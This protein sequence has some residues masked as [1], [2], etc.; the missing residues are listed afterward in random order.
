MIRRKRLTDGGILRLKPGGKE[1]TVWDT[2][3]PGLGVRVWPSGSRGYVVLLRPPGPSRRVSL[4]SAMLKTIHEA[5]RECLLIQLEGNA[6][7]A[8]AAPPPGIPAPLFRDFVADPWMAA[9][10]G[11]WKPSTLRGIESLL[12]SQLLPAFGDLPV[13]RIARADV[14]AWFDRFSARSPGNANKGLELLRQIMNHAVNDGHVAKNPARLTRANP[15]P[16]LTRFLS[17]NE[18]A[19]LHEALDACVAERPDR[20]MQAEI[21]RLLLY[22]GCR[23]SEIRDL[24]WSEVCGDTLRLADSKTGPRTVFL[25]ADA[26]AVIERQRTGQEGVYVFPSPV[27]PGRPLAKE[28]SLWPRVREKAGLAGVRL[29]DLRHT[30]ASQAVMKGVPLPVVARLLGHTE[31]RMTMRYAHVGDHEIVEAAERIGQAIARALDGPD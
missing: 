24:R 10:R 12:R 9:R 4:G 30:Y 28:L 3:A 1:Y 29:H 17:A 13:D 14:D 22:T 26:R 18:I 19:R 25:S 8:G 15:R 7:A 6:A 21:I 11:R 31:P 16:R 23:R 20:E 2:A 5:R 27:L